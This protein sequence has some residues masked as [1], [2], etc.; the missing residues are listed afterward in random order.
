MG[1]WEGYTEL[2]PC[3]GS[4]GLLTTLTMQQPHPASRHLYLVPRSSKRCRRYS[5]RVVVERSSH[6]T[7]TFL[8]SPLCSQRCLLKGTNGTEYTILLTYYWAALSE[9]HLIVRA[10]STKKDLHFYLLAI[11]GTCKKITSYLCYDGDLWP[12]YRTGKM[13]TPM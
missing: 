13:V 8:S 2:T 11:S 7:E 9:K 6:P 12:V 1:F 10:P 4:P 5:S 3:G